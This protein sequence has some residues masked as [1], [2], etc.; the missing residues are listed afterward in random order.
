[1]ICETCP[2]I[3]PD[4]YHG[5][6]PEEAALNCYCDK[7][8][9]KIF[10]FGPCEKEVDRLPK[11]EYRNPRHLNRYEREKHYKDREKRM[12][13]DLWN[14]YLA[15]SGIDKDEYYTNDPNEIVYVKRL[16]RGSRSKFLKRRSNKKVRRYQRE[17]PNH[18]GYR[19]VFDFWWELY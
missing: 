12:A 5:M 9:C 3:E 16:Y 6:E 17:F 14:T 10:Y 2:Y 19:R 13:I 8:G 15:P 11:K 4:E 18:G 1:M 7:L